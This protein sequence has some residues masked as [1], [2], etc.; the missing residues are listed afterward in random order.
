ME[1]VRAELRAT[2]RSVVA[3]LILGGTTIASVAMSS[4]L[5]VVQAQPPAFAM[6]ARGYVNSPARC[7]APQTAVLVGRTPLSLIAVC[8]D[9]GGHYEYRGL[10]L[11]DGALLRLPAEPNANGSFRARKE[12]ITYT[13]SEH[14][15]LLTTGVRVV[16]D[17]AMLDFKDFREPV[18]APVAKI[19]G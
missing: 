12:K 3:A 14:K 2:L 17:E 10:R 19:F 13:I 6:D 5:P 8:K 4:Y 18:E 7:D 1:D 16:R 15:L 9:K 11:R